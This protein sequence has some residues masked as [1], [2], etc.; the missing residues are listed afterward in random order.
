MPSYVYTI[1]V[2]IFL[3]SLLWKSNQYIQR[4]FENICDITFQ[5]GCMFNIVHISMGR[6]ENLSV[7]DLLLPDKLYRP[8]SG[9]D[10]IC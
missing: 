4:L 1:C 2:T 8:L 9:F 7:H 6:I 5:N 10:A 3:K